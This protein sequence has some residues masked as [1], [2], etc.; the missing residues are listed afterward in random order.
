MSPLSLWR[1]SYHDFTLLCKGQRVTEDVVTMTPGW[2]CNKPDL[3]MKETTLYSTA[4]T[5][6]KHGPHKYPWSFARLQYPRT[7]ANTTSGRQYYRYITDVTHKKPNFLF[8]HFLWN[9]TESLRLQL[10]EFERKQIHFLRDV[11][12]AVAVVLVA[13]TSF[14]SWSMKSYSKIKIA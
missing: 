8:F 4:M 7:S 11:F 14:D 10:Q 12:T 1:G 2:S 13:Q 3:T 5:P 6:G 9:W